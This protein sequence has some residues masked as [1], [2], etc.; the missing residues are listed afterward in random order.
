MGTATI[1][2]LGIVI[3]LAPVAVVTVSRVDDVSLRA[4]TVHV[5]GTMLIVTIVAVILSVLMGW[6]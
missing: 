6:F 4:A 3:V 5:G 2:L 1:A